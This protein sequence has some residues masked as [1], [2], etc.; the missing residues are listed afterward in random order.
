M[1]T[2]YQMKKEE[3]IA[4]C[5]KLQSENERLKDELEDLS[6]CYTEMENQLAVQFNS[7]NDFTM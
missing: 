2:L 3:L 5:K 7:M 4:L 6:D 1:K